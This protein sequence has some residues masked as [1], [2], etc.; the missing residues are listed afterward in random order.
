MCH[1]AVVSRSTAFHVILFDL[2]GTLTDSAPGI[3]NCIR[4]ALDDMGIEYPADEAMRRHLG[5]PLSETFGVHFGMSDADIERAIAKYRERFHDVG[6]FENAVYDGIPDL[7]DG[8]AG[9]GAV[10]AVST[11]KPTPSATRI[12]EHYELAD[13]FAFIGGAELHGPRQHKA[14]VIE[15]T[16]DELRIRESYATDDTVAM[17]GDREHDMRGAAAHGIPGIGV[18]W[19]YGTDDELR[20]AGAR[21][22]VASPAAL[23]ALLT[24]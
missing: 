20:A 1:I 15:H 11:S 24:T 16:L 22:V 9:A 13:R 12:L 10:L 17:I 7:L 14:D 18:L 23:L 3:L 2:D 19:G 21:D 6:M 5:P 8:L 4:Y